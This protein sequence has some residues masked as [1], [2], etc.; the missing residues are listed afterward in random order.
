MQ[1]PTHLLLVAMFLVAGCTTVGGGGAAPSPTATSP[2]ATSEATVVEEEPETGSGDFEDIPD[3]V[4]D[5]APSVVS[6]QVVAQRQGQLAQGAGSGVIWNADGVIVT[7]NHVVEGAQEITVFLADGTSLP[8]E[9]LATDPRTDLAVIQVDRSDLPPADFAPR[10]PEVGEL[11]VALGNPLG[12]QNSA[13]AGIVS[14]LDR[15]V[16]AQGGSV[17]VG[18]IQTDAPISPGNSGGALV[19]GK[20]RIIGINVA[21]AAGAGGAENL[22]FAIPATTV[23]PVVEELLAEGEVT[24]PYL[25]I[26]GASLTPQVAQRFGIDREAGVVVAEVAPGGPAADAGIEPGDLI[27][28]LGGSE[29]ANFGDLVAALRQHDPGDAVSV[30]VVRDGQERTVEATLDELPSP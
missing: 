25:G 7:N 14:G 12:L 21:K 9:V 2:E 16:P 22:G 23:V 1:R 10:L 5:V 4:R 29:V 28:A 8:A 18:L 13:T 6:I 26:R 27:V 17:L 24:H 3:I 30:T 20:R 11:A 19:D 15:S